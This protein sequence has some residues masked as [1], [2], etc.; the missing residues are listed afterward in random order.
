MGIYTYSAFY[1]GRLL[2]KETRDKLD[3][4]ILKANNIEITDLN[5]ARGRYVIHPKDCY[6]IISSI[7]PATVDELNKIFPPDRI[8]KIMSD[9]NAH[10]EKLQEIIK[11]ISDNKSDLV[12]FYIV[13]CSWS[14]LECSNAMHVK[15]NI[16][17][18][19]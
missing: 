8:L 1:F 4:E 6:I 12:D 5:D 7:D 11:Q 15:S 9:A 17:I 2:T 3:D 16:R 13:E 10:K 18:E 14:T 19:L